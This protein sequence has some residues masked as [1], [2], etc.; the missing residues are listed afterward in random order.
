[1]DKSKGV[2]EEAREISE[3]EISA[4]EEELGG[5]RNEAESGRGVKEGMRNSTDDTRHFLPLKWL[6]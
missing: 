2:G 3:D 1:M 4:E 6:F 5:V